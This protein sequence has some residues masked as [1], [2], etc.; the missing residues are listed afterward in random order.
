M[1]PGLLGFL[2]GVHNNPAVKLKPGSTVVFTVKGRN[3]NGSWTILL[4]GK[5][6]TVKSEAALIPG[7]KMR[8]RVSVQGGRVFLRLMDADKLSRHALSELRLPVTEHYKNIVDSLIKTGLPLREEL[9]TA[10]VRQ[11][12]SLSR[13]DQIS[14][15]VLALLYDKGLSLSP[16]DTDSLIKAVG[17]PLDERDENRRRR[18]EHR[19][20]GSEE[21]GE[22]QKKSGPPNSR[23]IRRQVERSTGEEGVLP[24]FNHVRGAHEH[25]VVVPFHITGRDE[26]AVLRF[27][28]DDELKV[29][30]FTFSVY[31]EKSWHFEGRD[32]GKKRRLVVYSNDKRA[33]EGSRRIVEELRKKL[34][35][36]PWEIDDTIREA[37]DFDPFVSEKNTDVHGVDTQV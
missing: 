17:G 8:A 30:G 10:L 27:S 15:R 34:H 18:G 11:Y 12:N 37:S 5:E 9:I 21:E 28:I 23:E 6:L 14:S 3:S 33:R 31:G 20:D 19:G 1:L 25:W 4:G 29:G 32:A 36:L 35:N 2:E 7:E 13:Q 26:N 16:E 24:L 22:E